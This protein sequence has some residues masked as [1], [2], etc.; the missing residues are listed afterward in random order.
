M[1]RR[2]RS[3]MVK[4][5]ICGITNWTDA[6]TAVEHGADFLGF[7]FYRKSPRY[8]APAVAARIVKKLPRRVKAVGV[9]VNE[10]E[11]DILG[12]A[13]QVKL[14]R[15]QLHGD[16]SPEAVERLQ[17]EFAVI[18]AIRVRGS[19]LSSKL[20]GFAKAD[21]LL[22]DGFDRRQYGGTGKT[23]DWKVL[24]RATVRQNV[25][26]AGGLTAENVAEAI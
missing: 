14:R 13:R 7:N 2:N 11:A 6:R 12:I 21:A 10:P 19:A 8:V 15:L 25:F 18:K 1:V 16:E 22:L 24:R 20:K 23:F 9:F 5:K 3:A 4:V 17:R 26:L